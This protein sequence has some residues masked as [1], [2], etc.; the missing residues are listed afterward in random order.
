MGRRRAGLDGLDRRR[1]PDHDALPDHCYR[2]PV[3]AAPAG[4]PRYRQLRRQDHPHRR[5]GRRLRPDRQ[6]RR[7]DRH[8]RH[9]RSTRPGDRP[10]AR[11]AHRLPAHRHLGHAEAG[12]PDPQAGAAHVRPAAADATAGPARQ[13]RA[14]RGDDGHR[15]A[16]L[17]AGECAEP[18]RRPARDEPPA[19]AGARSGTAPQAHPG[20]RLRLQAADL[21]QR[22]LP[23]LQPAQRPSRNDA[24]RADRAGR[25]R[26]RRRA[27]DARSTRSCSPPATTS[28]TRTSR[29]SR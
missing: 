15:G 19:P 5:L 13:H 20:L 14:A 17:P 18:R 3:P 8:R 2:L 6:A 22:L 1:R 4:H 27:Q 24:D 16:A 12:R 7:G 10:E 29:P 28:G 25:H 26:H 9:R 21:L 11:R 23:D